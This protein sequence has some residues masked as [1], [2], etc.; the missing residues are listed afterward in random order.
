VCEITVKFEVSQPGA[1]LR[2][3]KEVENKTRPYVHTGFM[4]WFLV[5]QGWF[6]C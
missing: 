3:K 1:R 4:A 5:V 2:E 6:I